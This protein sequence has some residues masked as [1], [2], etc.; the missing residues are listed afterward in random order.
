MSTCA[1]G[2]NFDA[3]RVDRSDPRLK[4]QPVGA[5]TDEIEKAFGSKASLKKRA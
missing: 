1:M 3:V 2:T 5:V 4:R